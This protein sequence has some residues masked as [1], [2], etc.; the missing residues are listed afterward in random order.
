MTLLDLGTPTTDFAEPTEDHSRRVDFARLR[1]TVTRWSLAAAGVAAI[2]QTAG[3][4]VA[5]R[6]A[7][8]PTGSLVSLLALC[9]VGAALLD[10][11]G[12][13]AWAGA[14]APAGGQ[15]RAHPLPAAPPPP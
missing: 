15:P 9:I 4:I 14:V 5:G 8:H 10:T 12:R 11:T 1:G 3:T 2:G 6:I 7:E 13:A